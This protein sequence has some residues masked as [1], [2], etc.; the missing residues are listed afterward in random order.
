MRCSLSRWQCCIDC[1]QFDSDINLLFYRESFVQENLLMYTKLFQVFLNRTVRTDLVN[2][3][4]ALMVF[5]VAKV[6]AQPNL[7]E[8]IQK[9]EKR[10]ANTHMRWRHAV[11]VFSMNQ[12]SV[13]LGYLS[14]WKYC[15][16]NAPFLISYKKCW[17]FNCM[18]YRNGS[19]KN[20]RCFVHQPNLI[21]IKWDH[22]Q[23]RTV[24]ATQFWWMIYLLNNFLSK[25]A[26]NSLGS[27]VLVGKKITR[28]FGLWE[29]MMWS[30]VLFSHIL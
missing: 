30:F 25:N 16:N 19:F 9:G 23:H 5:R 10:N 29:N 28:H 3:K 8:M 1:S 11:T 4:N 7:A 12:L 6:F 21:R 18:E 27:G 24:W 2:A 20:Y 14:F 17:Y 15:G 26:K 22:L 13:L